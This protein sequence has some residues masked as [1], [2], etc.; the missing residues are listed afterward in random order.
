MHDQNHFQPILQTLWALY[1]VCY[2]QIIIMVVCL[3]AYSRN[4]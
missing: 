2:F 1:S 4:V 3:Q